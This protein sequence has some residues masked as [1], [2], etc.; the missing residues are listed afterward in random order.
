VTVEVPG[1]NGRRLAGVM[2]AVEE[3]RIASYVARL[4]GEASGW[5]SGPVTA[6][7]SATLD[8]D[9]SGLEV[10]GDCHLARALIG[11]CSASSS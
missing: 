2:V 1:E 8:G 4:R 9:S 10:G 3:G 7:L 6:W 11:R 5:A